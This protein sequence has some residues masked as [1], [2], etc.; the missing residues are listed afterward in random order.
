M[1]YGKVLKI[2]E[3]VTKKITLGGQESDFKIPNLI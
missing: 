3:T 2:E 1:F